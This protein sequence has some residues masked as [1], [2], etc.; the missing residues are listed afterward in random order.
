MF[1]FVSL[2]VSHLLSVEKVKYDTS[3]CEDDT[4]EKSLDVKA[5]SCTD[6]SSYVLI[7]ELRCLLLDIY[8]P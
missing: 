7:T 2:G 3:V 6:K 1:Y 4:V 5:Q 8:M